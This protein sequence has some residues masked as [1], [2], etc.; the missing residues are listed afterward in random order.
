M[1]EIPE[2]STVAKQLNESI[3]GKRIA[4]ATANAAGH[5][6][7][8]FYGDPE[9]YNERLSGET[10]GQARS[11]GGF[12]EIDA[13]KAALLFGDGVNVRYAAPGEKISINPKLRID[14][15]DGSALVCTIQ[16]YGGMWAFPKYKFDNQYYQAA[17]EKPSPLSGSF[18]EA[19][20]GRLFAG[21]KNTLSIKALL[22]TEQRIPGLG[23]GVLQ[24]ILF[25][26]RLHPKR[27][28]T[29]LTDA[30]AQ[31]LF[32]CVKETLR[33]M[34]AQGGR[35]TEKDL[36]GHSGGYKTVLS[37]KTY[38]QPCAVCGGAILREAYLGGNVYYC[39]NC[40][41]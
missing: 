36:Y 6:F 17:L 21:T 30:D 18:D 1:L 11:A 29:T 5:K 12:I 3:N 7:A 40:Q 9:A 35:D 26:A 20:F 39:P 16:M 28:L 14:F 2:S 19:Y 22:A 41:H 15:E 37:S 4:K 13:G 27:K 24:D 25:N 8:W 33:A 38:K 32:S 10:V 34:T 23:N 31:S